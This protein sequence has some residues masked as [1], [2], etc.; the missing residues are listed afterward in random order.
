MPPKHLQRIVV[1][2]ADI[3][4]GESFGTIDVT[5]TVLSRPQPPLRETFKG[6]KRL[7]RIG[8]RMTVDEIEDI[9]EDGNHL[10]FDYMALMLCASMIA[11]G[12]LIG[13]SSA[14]VIA[15]MLVSPLMG[16]ILS[17]TYGCAVMKSNIISRGL[18][19]EIVGV[20]ISLAVGFVMGVA[21]AH[22]YG[23]EYRSEQMITRGQ[24]SGLLMGIVIAAP[25]AVAVVLAVAK[26][27][28][29]AIIGTAISVSLLPPVVNCG[30]CMGFALV[31]YEG[32]K[33]DAIVFFNTGLMSFLLW[34]SNFLIIVIFGFGTFRYIKNVHPFVTNYKGLS[35]T[36]RTS[37][38][39][40]L[41]GFNLNTSVI[42]EQNLLTDLIAHS[43]ESQKYNEIDERLDL[44]ARA[45]SKDGSLAPVSNIEDNPISGSKYKPPVMSDDV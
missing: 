16:P 37:S 35:Q 43:D 27:G 34:F 9:I 2:L 22:I 11:G 33:S 30:V 29:N 32:Y 31:F 41:S 24:M 39:S 45:V 20:L 7:Y 4:C 17:M 40:F 19:N 23:H 1:A 15:S 3:G 13:D 26:G 18:R 42:Y 36:T 5:A 8:D 44:T 12:G 10:T 6:K 25:S 28:F 38:F 14:S 21:S